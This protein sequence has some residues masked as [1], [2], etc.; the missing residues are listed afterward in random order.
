MAEENSNSDGGSPPINPAP[1]PASNNNPPAASP[2]PAPIV[3]D[4]PADWRLK[5][6]GGDEKRAK[7]M[8]KY[9]SPKDVADAHLSLQQQLSTGEYKKKLSDKATPEEIAAWRKENGVPE[10]PEKYD[11]N[12]PDGLV[13]GE[14]DMPVAKDF[15]TVMHGLNA[16]Q[17]T[18]TAALQWWAKNAQAALQKRGEEDAEFK[19]AGEDAL[20]A[21]WGGEYR[22]NDNAIANH[23]DGLSPELQES[24]K[25]ARGADGRLLWDSPAFR[26]YM[27][28]QSLVENPARL[29]VPGSGG[30]SVDNIEQQLAEI[31]KISREEPARYNKDTKMQ[32]RRQKLLNAKAALDKRKN[33]A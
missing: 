30:D 13:L 2:S 12:L 27:L 22:M 33:A 8:E 24:L 21:E 32:E 29:V 19:R 7:A 18:V 6:A 1:P 23:I 16:D 25:G 9:A 5:A 11:Y 31:A 14:N 3:P 26:S 20:R 4:W 15:A 17:K 28:R 10:A